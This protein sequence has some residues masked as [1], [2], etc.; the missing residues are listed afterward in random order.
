MDSVVISIGVAVLMFA[1][2][3]LG[4]FLQRVLPEGHTKDHSRDMIG[5][6][7]GLITLLLALVLGLLIWTAFGVFNT[8]KTELQ[9]L[10]A[11]AL[12]FDLEMAQYG[13][14]GKQ[15]REV[16]RKDL[17]WAVEQFWGTDESKAA[18]YDASYANMNSMSAF[19]ENLHPTTD[20]QRGLLAQ[21]SA[22]Y[23]SIGENRLLMSLQLVDA[24]SWPLIVTVTAWSC[25]LFC[26]FGLLS[27]VNP[28]TLVALALG[29]CS[30]ASAI[31]L[32]LDFSQPYTSPLR[33]S[34]AALEQ[35]IVVL[36]K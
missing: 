30:V 5:A 31:F 35:V 8:Q 23:G 18:A 1:S 32:I 17:V 19:L 36:D 9:T 33:I 22:H 11:R 15:G 12:E 10:A 28:T 20:A 29:A 25:L 2:G 7:I 4:L 34:P 27:R 6:M 24:V 3:L 14:E 21:A 16:L 26:G 13:P